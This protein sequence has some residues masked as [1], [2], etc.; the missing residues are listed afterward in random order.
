MLLLDNVVQAYGWG[1]RNGLARLLATAPTDEPEAELW[2]GTH[3]RG[4]SVV[5]AGPHR[6]Q[7]L[8]EV[9][10]ADPATWLGQEAA[11]KGCEALPYLLKVL[12]IGRPLSLQAH[13][14]VKQA[15]GG[16][17]REDATGVPLDADRRSYRDTSDKPELLV[18]LEET[19]VLC[20]FRQAEDAARRVRLLGDPIRPLLGLL[21]VSTEPMRD[22]IS[23]LLHLSTGDAVRVAQAADQVAVA[24]TRADHPDPDDPWSWVRALTMLHPDDATCIAPLLLELVH[25]DVGDAVHLPAGNLHAYLRGAGVE[26]MASSDN[27]LRGGLTDKHVDVGELLHVVRFDPGTPPAPQQRRVGAVR[28]YLAG[29]HSFALAAIEPSPTTTW[30]RITAPSLFL[31]VGGGA[32]IASES[33][34]LEVA[35]GQAVALAP[36]QEV[37]VRSDVTVWW[38]TTGDGLPSDQ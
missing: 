38:A 32:I 22:A 19:Y 8:A 16:F 13:P 20:G 23:W 27:V 36:G 14:N 9:I 25:L 34:R 1:A 12:A 29:E 6:G 10:A 37:L 15:L 17:E 31:P 28:C 21:E 33:E 18:A 35:G 11:S 7:T 4:P 2:V 30:L 24:Q 3:P 26:V 5:A